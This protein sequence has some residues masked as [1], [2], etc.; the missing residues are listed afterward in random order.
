MRITCQRIG[1]PP[2]S[3]SAFGIAW[4]RSCRRVPRPPQRIATGVEP[5]TGDDCPSGRAGASAA[6]DRRKDLDLV[7]VAELGFEP[8]LEADVLTGDEDV[9]EA[10]QPA[11]LGDALAEAVVLLE[12][13]VERLADG[14]PL[15]LQLAL[16]PGSRSKLGRDLDRD[17]HRPEI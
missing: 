2:I 5:S 11:V 10:A 1:R 9:H 4:V 17:A 15:D 13:G 6:G 16:A 7:A 3:T 12:D 8:V 14:R